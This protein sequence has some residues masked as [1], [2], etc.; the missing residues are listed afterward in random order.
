MKKLFSL[1][2]ASMSEGMNLFKINTKKK[3]KFNKGALPIILALVLMFTMYVYSDKLMFILAPFGLGYVV[4]TL[5]ALGISMLTLIEGIYK[6]GNL[7]FNCKD[8]NMLLSL[9]IKRSTVLFIRVFKFYMFEL[10]YNSVFLLPTMINYAVY[11]HPSTSYY[12]LSVIALLLLP[13]VPILISCV[14]GTI[15]T[16]VASK[17]KGK[18]I[19]QTIL[20]IAV[21]LVVLFVSYNSNGLVQSITEHATSI[22]DTI[23]KYYYPVGEYVNLVTNFNTLKLLAYV[24]IHLVLFALT[25]VLIGRIYFSVNSSSKSIKKKNKTSKEYKIK[26]STPVNSLIKKEFTR[27][28]NSP[29]FVS[30]AGFGL[31]LYIIGCVFVAIK[32]NSF[33]DSIVGIGLVESMEQLIS[34]IPLLAFAFLCFTAFMTSITSS[35]ISLEGK[36]F[37]ILKSLPQKPTTIVKAKILTAII[38][39]LPCIFIGDLILFIRFKL[40]ILS[41]LLILIASVLLPLISETIGIIIN[42]KYPRMDAQNDTEVVKQSMSSSI[43]VFIGMGIIAATI[44]GMFGAVS[45]GLSNIIIILIFTGVFALIY[46]LLLLILSKICDKS[47]DN[48]NV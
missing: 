21:I 32:F 8:D 23:T 47:F 7:L 16:S 38:I 48:I 25:V 30:N 41:I 37:N 46:G 31:V 29:V 42:L 2:K 33:A 35:M 39:M 20:S 9:P 3:S 40:D 24:G 18:N 6:S 27:F 34:F 4:L 19:V 26:T 10:L 14:L 11:V 36:S 43:S 44:G 22:S 13:V 17:F 1:I 12:V 15:I 45:A 5:F 28:I